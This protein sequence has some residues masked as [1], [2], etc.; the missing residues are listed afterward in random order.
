[1]V[2]HDASMR[3]TLE[4][5]D[6]LLVDR[7]A[8]ARRPPRVGDV[9]VLIDPEQPSRWLVKRVAAVDPATGTVDVRGD[10]TDV[11]RDSRR[12]GPVATSA[13]VGRAYR[14]YLPRSRRRDL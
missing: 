5:G 7:G 9:V 11:A 3:P 14:L 4:P 10:A 2:V 1:V 13:I 12:F 8:Y 6:R